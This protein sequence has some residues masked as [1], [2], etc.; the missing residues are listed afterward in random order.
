MIDLYL[1][2]HQGLSEQ[3]RMRFSRFLTIGWA[4]VLFA[5]ALLSRRGGHVVEAGL[6]IASILSGAMLGV[7][8]LG[9]LSRRSSENGAMAGMI[10]GVVVNLLLWLQPRDLVWQFFGW[11]ITL[12]KV[13]YMWWVLIGSMVTVFI[14]YLASLILP[15]RTPSR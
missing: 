7:F 11:S 14:G 3:Q 8:L 10:A 9:V 15:A 5:L 2:R 13:A 12:P 4:V 6:S 1:P